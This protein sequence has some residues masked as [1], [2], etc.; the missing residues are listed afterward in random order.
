M[1]L[2]MP[3]K[4]F[5]GAVLVLLVQLGVAVPTLAQ[6]ADGD[7][8]WQGPMVL[9][10]DE[11]TFQRSDLLLVRQRPFAVSAGWEED[12]QEPS[13]PV[14]TDAADHRASDDPH[15]D[16]IDRYRAGRGSPGC[17]CCR[18]GSAGSKGG[19]QILE[20]VRSELSPQWHGPTF[21]GHQL[22][23]SALLRRV[24]ARRNVR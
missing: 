20:P 3:T 24:D 11:P 10:S 19:A 18:G 2:L 21:T 23:Q 16:G 22:A 6:A 7:I 8:T 12:G 1:K 5:F 13:Y 17:S 4:N 9:V 14:E 15:D